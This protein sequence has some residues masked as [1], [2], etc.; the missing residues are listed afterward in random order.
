MENRL[1][2]LMHEEEKMHK[3]IQKAQRHTLFAGK[4]ND[5]R[6]DDYSKKVNH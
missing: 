2:K 3:E 4:V 1:K 5:R 6:A